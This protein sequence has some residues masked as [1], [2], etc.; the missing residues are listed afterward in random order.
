MRSFTHYLVSTLL[1]LQFPLSYAVKS[2][3]PIQSRQAT[4][5]NAAAIQ[6]AIPT[7]ARVQWAV[8]KTGNADFDY[9]LQQTNKADLCATLISFTPNDG[10]QNPIQL[11]ML[12]P[13]DRPGGWNQRLL[14]VG[15]GG[16]VGGVSWAAMVTGAFEGFATMSTDTGHTEAVNSQVFADDPDREKDWGMRAMNYSVLVAKAV[17]RGYYSKAPGSKVL[18]YYSGCS[19]GGRQ[20][21]RQAQMDANSF[22]G[23]LI[24]AP[25]WDFNHLMA[26]AAQVGNYNLQAPSGEKLV[27]QRHFDLIYAEVMRQCNQT[28]FDTV[29]DGIVADIDSCRATFDWTKVPTCTEHQPGTDCLTPAQIEI[30]KSMAKDE[31]VGGVRVFE[32]FELPSAQ[33]WATF[34]AD[35]SEEFDKQYM[36]YFLEHPEWTW[37]E[38][39][40]QILAEGDTEAQKAKN[41]AAAIDMAALGR[42]NGKIILY[43]GMADGTIPTRSTRRLFTNVPNKANVRYFEIPGL[44]HCWNGGDEVTTRGVRA[45]WYIGGVGLAEASFRGNPQSPTDP[46]NPR[47]YRYGIP[48]AGGLNNTMND[49]LNALVAWAEGSADA[50]GSLVATSFTNIRDAGDTTWYKKLRQRRIC[51][52]PSR[53][54]L[55]DSSKVDDMSSWRCVCDPGVL[56]C[57]V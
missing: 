11:G 13:P 57:T 55:R 23:M 2:S 50:P 48:Q 29:V 51:H 35:E 22:D 20:G 54:D 34:L 30:A 19:T 25:A 45:P 56:N 37:Q 15:N 27:A 6:S 26:R 24:G 33:A 39:A 40:A 10:S 8:T 38:N 1:S 52:Y 9:M 3:M 53:A 17:V 7:Y 46:L 42:Y 44:Q 21:L 49:A 5:C 12:L 16:F 14:T 41:G 28:G 18:S 4:R 47:L 43:H 31:T 36:R 32:G